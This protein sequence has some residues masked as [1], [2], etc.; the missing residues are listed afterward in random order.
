MCCCNWEEGIYIS[1]MFYLPHSINTYYCIT[2]HYAFWILDPKR[3]KGSFRESQAGLPGDLPIV[4]AHV[5]SLTHHGILSSW[6]SHVIDNYFQ[7]FEIKVSYH[8]WQELLKLVAV[9]SDCTL[10]D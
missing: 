8:F 6:R 3:S 10:S 5:Y 4:R 7:T 2:H 1:H 9:V